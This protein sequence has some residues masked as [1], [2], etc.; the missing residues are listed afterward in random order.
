VLVDG[1]VRGAIDIPYL[2][3]I[4]AMESLT[5]PVPSLEEF[6][7]EDRPP[8]TLT[9]LAFQT[10]IGI[11]TLLAALV[12]AYWLLRW[13]GRDLLDPAT[14]GS[15]WFLR[16]AVAAGPLA[17][18]ALQTGWITTEVGRQPWI[19]YGVMRTQDAAADA[20]GVLWWV[21]GVSVLLYAAMTVGAVVVLRSMARRWRAGE[22]DLPSPYGPELQA[23]GA[24]GAEPGG[25]AR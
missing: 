12:A 22:E 16:V 18:V 4:I 13:R 9:H 17:V 8:A 15:R 11:G 3:S 2:G 20:S 7:E 21:Y 10:M 19:V 14:R 1:E 6:P 24:V 5:E 23:V 25:E